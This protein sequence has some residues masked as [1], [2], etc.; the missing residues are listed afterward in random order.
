VKYTDYAIGKFIREAS[1]KPWFNNTVFVIV[2]DHCAGSAGSVE[3]PVTGY[4]IPMIMYSPA[5]LPPQKIDRLTAQ[6]DI[7]PSILGLLKFNYRSQFFGQDIFTLPAGD[8]RAFI[9]TYQGL[10]Y[11]RNGELII[12]SPIGQI[13]QFKPDFTT[14]K[15]QKEPLTD[16]LVKQAIAYYQSAVWL[17]KNNKYQAK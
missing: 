16:S 9:S 10:G 8:E 6:V 13:E 15:A 5:N 12:Q 14:G 11:L 2:A 1:Q 7:A 17:L 3:L 4:H